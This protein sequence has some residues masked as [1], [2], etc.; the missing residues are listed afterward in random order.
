MRAGGWDFGLAWS[1]CL[2]IKAREAEMYGNGISLPFFDASSS[3]YYLFIII[4]KK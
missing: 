2:F 1:W 3:R 4:V